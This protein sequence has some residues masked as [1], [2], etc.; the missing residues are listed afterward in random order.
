MARPKK[1]YEFLE[2]RTINGQIIY[3]RKCP[4]CSREVLHENRYG[5][6]LSHKQNRNCYEC[7]NK[8]KPPVPP[9]IMEMRRKK[10][11]ET[12][13]G[14]CKNAPRWN[15][16]LTKEVSDILSKMGENHT[17]FKHSDLT[18]EIISKASKDRWGTPE[19]RKELS[20]MW[21]QRWKDGCYENAIKNGLFGSRKGCT[22]KKGKKIEYTPEE[23]TIKR[24]FKIYRHQVTKFTKKVEHL[25]EGYDPSKQGRCGVKGAY[26]IDH[27][28]SVQYGFLNGIPPEKIADSKNLQFITWEENLARKKKV[29]VEKN[30]I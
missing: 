27:I 3:I 18:K 14:V 20:K 6:V 25:V 13:K 19:G 11:S 16:G 22:H 21:K 29:Y 24:L 10:Q 5:C 12:M 28:I 30:K 2:E 1:T 9:D 23:L 4:N 8:L 7:A 26:Q 17:G 15:T